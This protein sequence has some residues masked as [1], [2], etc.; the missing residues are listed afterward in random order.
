MQAKGVIFFFPVVLGFN[1]ESVLAGQEFHHLTTPHINTLSPPP[2]LF[3][4]IFQVGS[5]FCPRPHP[6]AILPMLPL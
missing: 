3:Y 1:S 2:S 6:T 5:Q 4:V